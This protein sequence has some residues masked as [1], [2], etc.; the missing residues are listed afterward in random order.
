M[1]K[2]Q[3]RLILLTLLGSAMPSL[4]AALPTPKTEAPPSF[5]LPTPKTEAPPSFASDCGTISGEWVEAGGRIAAFSGIRYGRPPVGDLRWQ[6]S[7][8]V[9]CADVS[10]NATV[11]GNVC[12]QDQTTFGQRSEDCLNLN[13]F[14]PEA[15]L[16]PGARAR[17]IVVWIY[18]GSLVLGAPISYGSIF[19]LVNALDVILVAPSYRLGMLGWAA[20][21]ALAARDVRQGS[22]GGN[23]GLTDQIN[24]LQWVRRNAAALGGDAHAVTLMGQSSGGTSIVG[25]L[26]APSASGLFQRAISL[27]ASPNITMGV[28]QKHSYDLQNFA[29]RTRCTAAGDPACL[30]SLSPQEILAATSEAYNSAPDVDLLPTG[31]SPA[32]LAWGP[33][34]YV[35]GATVREPS[36][37]PSVAGLDVILQSVLAED[38]FVPNATVLAFDADRALQFLVAH[39]SGFPD[40]AKLAHTLYTAYS[41]ACS[42]DRGG[43]NC[44][45]G[46]LVYEMASDVNVYCGNAQLASDLARAGAHVYSS[47]W[48]AAPGRTLRMRNLDTAQECFRES[49][50]PMHMIDFIWGAETFNTSGVTCAYT[51][52]RSDIAL[53]VGIRSVWRSMVHG[54]AV[55]WWKQANATE[56]PPL[57]TISHAYPQGFVGGS[58]EALCKL[59]ADAGVGKSWWWIN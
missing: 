19:S 56:F 46:G 51:P 39:M 12:W 16:Q 50:L 3:L 6:P 21:P 14:A 20:L 11:P 42:V 52:T 37:P 48:T 38:A 18:G 33:L 47:L 5:A 54:Q 49:D 26:L 53:G 34:L 22:G 57:N 15:A 17:P 2:E 44:A 13:V 41:A 25:L 35:D 29:A 4:E 9:S 24:A 1:P 55:P 45:P 58:R 8:R 43:E 23:Y 31:P 7:L 30:L 32:G 36:F 28:P 27:S 40:A 59:W 10:M